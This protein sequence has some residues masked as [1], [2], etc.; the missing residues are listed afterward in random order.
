MRFREKPPKTGKRFEPSAVEILD[1]QGRLRRG[2][3]SEGEALECDQ[4][5]FSSPEQL[6]LIRK[7][8]R[9]YLLAGG[10][11]TVSGCAA[12]IAVSLVDPVSGH[13]TEDRPASRLDQNTLTIQLDGRQRLG[14]MEVIV[15]AVSGGD[16]QKEIGTRS[17]PKW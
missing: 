6:F 13:R 2:W 16:T 17:S 15:G 7:G 12:P 8:S 11:V 10:E 9:R 1:R 14:W 3:S 4:I 5:K